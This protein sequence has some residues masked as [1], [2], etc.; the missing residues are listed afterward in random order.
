[1]QHKIETHN[2]KISLILLHG[3]HTPK[4]KNIAIFAI[5]FLLHNFKTLPTCHMEFFWVSNQTYIFFG[6]K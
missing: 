4:L 1:M 5:A 3:H 2:F 6:D